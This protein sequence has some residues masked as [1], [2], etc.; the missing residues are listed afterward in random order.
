MN[1]RDY[2]TYLFPRTLQFRAARTGLL[3]PGNP[4]TLTYSVTAACQSKCKTCNIGLQYQAHPERKEADLRLDEIEKIFKSLEHIY[5][6]NI[7]GGEPFL[8]KD[9]PD[10]I[11]L[12]CKY[13]RP[14]IIHIPTNA[15]AS[16]AIRD[17][18][19]QC[20]EV[21]RRHDPKLPLTV[22]PSID[23]IG[24]MHDEIRGV[25]GNFAQLEKTIAY[26]KEVEAT[27][28]NFHLELGTVVSRFNM[29]RLSEI[30]DYVHSL[31]VQSYR[32]EIAEQRAEFF[33]LQDPITPDAETYARLIHG[34]K[35]KI[36]SGISKKRELTQV[37]EAFRLAYYD[38]AV[39]I[40]GE[41]RQ[42]IPCYG[43]IS[44]VHIN[45]DGEVWPCCVLG[46]SRPLGFLRESDYDFQQV[47]QSDRARSVRKYIK[48]RNCACPLANQAYSNILCS[49]LYLFKT[50]INFVKITIRS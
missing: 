49:P 22:K 36:L 27:Y 21:M 17:L 44:N 41:G 31:G 26:L 2:V 11:D 37:T 24:R 40:L 28:F 6:F 48:D 39:R 29:G 23:G 19:V 15:I 35:K 45:F 9:L 42:V 1:I 16:R 8:R 10:I 14:G 34:F 18:T 20:L 7:S 43:G 46:Y 13:L 12:A 4:L 33:N 3:K 25:K 47:W 5:F 32:N 30:E 50:F 38:L